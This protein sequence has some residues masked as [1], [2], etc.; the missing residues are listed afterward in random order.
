MTLKPSICYSNSS[1]N[2]E[3]RLSSFFREE[4]EL[5]GK[6]IKADWSKYLP[7]SVVA[8]TVSQVCI[9]IALVIS[10]FFRLSI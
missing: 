7:G 8:A 4:E 10:N 9:S 6:D 1:Y 3:K 5:G 2:D